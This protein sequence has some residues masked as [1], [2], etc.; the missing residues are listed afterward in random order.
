MFSR[1]MDRA[2]ESNFRKD[3]SE[4]L[5]FIPF[6]LKEKCYFVD[7]K[8]DEEKLRGFVKIFRSAI[9]L[10]SW[11]SFPIM[12]FP[13]LILEDIAGLSPRGHRL[14]IAI[15][16]PSFF[17]LALGVL[18]WMLWTIYKNTVPSVTFSMTEVGP[19]VKGQ[20]TELY[21][22]P[23]QVALSAALACAGVLILMIGAILGWQY[24]R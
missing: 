24:T 8:S 16:I 17:W 20:L 3:P 22:R 1:L 23:H 5:V 19:D 15:G 11:L 7:S 6:S 18:A 10:I 2:I 21:R 4:R 9:T 12:F 13:G 14:A